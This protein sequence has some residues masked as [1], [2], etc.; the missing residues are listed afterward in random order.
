MVTF[1][2][3]LLGDGPNILLEHTTEIENA[4]KI[5]NVRESIVTKG[6]ETIKRLL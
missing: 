6:L 1:K 4:K 2:S 5:N 3:G